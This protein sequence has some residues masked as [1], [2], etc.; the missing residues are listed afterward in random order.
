MRAYV[1]GY[2]EREKA[3]LHDQAETLTALLHGDTFYPAGSRVLEPGCGVAAQT[4][5]LAKN[6]PEARITSIDIDQ[7]S[8][9]RAR[10]LIA[11]ENIT[12]VDFQRADIFN[13]PFDKETFDHIFVCFTL[14]HLQH[15]ATALHCVRKVLKKGGSLTVIEGDHGSTYFHPDSVEA[16]KTV[17]CLVR[18]QADMGGNA[19]IGRQLYPLIKSA[20]FE[21]VSVS[22]RMVYVDSSKP[23]LVEGFTKNTFIAMVEAVKEK[24]LRS[25]MIKKKTWNK[26]I[27]DLYR[28]MEVDGTFCYT[29]FKG[30]GIKA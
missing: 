8:I 25:D 27:K 30:Q 15:P 29:F 16:Q 21:K 13:L 24:A 3:R 28:T 14:E 9:D 19:L 6:S 18:I 2:S 23:A 12:N 10:C 11:K 5:I 4:L 22:P 1:H 20:R 17:L 26:G 7:D